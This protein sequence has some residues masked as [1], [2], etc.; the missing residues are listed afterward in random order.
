MHCGMT[1]V[2]TYWVPFLWL[3]SM[4]SLRYL[5]WPGVGGCHKGEW[6]SGCYILVCPRAQRRGWCLWHLVGPTGQGLGPSLK[7]CP[8]PSK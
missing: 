5:A 7:F 2:T 3:A 4:S 8:L 1:V 6:D